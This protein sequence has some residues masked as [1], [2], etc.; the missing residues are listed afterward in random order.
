MLL[1]I[2]YFDQSHSGFRIA[3]RADDRSVSAGRQMQ[4]RRGFGRIAR[5]EAVLL[6]VGRT[7]VILPVVVR[8]DCHA[9][10]IKNRKRRIRQCI[11]ESGRGER[12]SI[13]RTTTVVLSTSP[14]MKPLI[15]T[16]SPEPTSARVLMFANFESARGERS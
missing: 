13:A 12:R 2:V 3:T 4:H 5:C 10:G 16:S 11:A 15:R 14:T 7:D 8:G 6:D 9:V 1:Q